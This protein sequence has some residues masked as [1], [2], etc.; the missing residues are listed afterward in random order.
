[1]VA[2]SG[3]GEGWGG[4]CINRPPVFFAGTHSEMR[5]RTKLLIENDLVSR[6]VA[7]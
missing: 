6:W 1:M 3:Y 7:Y 5:R 2:A 4:A